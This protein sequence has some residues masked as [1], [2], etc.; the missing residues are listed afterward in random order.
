MAEYLRS[1]DD[2]STTYTVFEPDQ[3]L[4]ETEL[5]AAVYYLDDQERLSRVELSGVGIVCGLRVSVTSDVVKLTKGIGVTTDGDL[6]YAKAVSSTDEDD[7]VHY[8][9]SDAYYSN[10]KPYIAGG[11]GYQRF[12]SGTSAI[13]AWELV[14]DGTDDPL[15]VS[16]GNF[17]TETGHSFD[18]MAALLLVESYEK[19]K[20]LCSGTDCDN[21]GKSSI[22]DVKLILIAK[23]ATGAFKESLATPDSAARALDDI[24]ATRAIINDVS[25]VS[26]FVTAHR[27]ACTAMLT[28]LKAALPK[29]YPACKPFLGDLFATDPSSAWITKLDGVLASFSSG[30]GIQYCYDFFKDVV[31]T[32]EAFRE[33][34]FDD[35]SVCCPKL[36]DFPKHLLLGNLNAPP[37]ST[38][39]RTGYYPSPAS[40]CT[41]GRLA[42]A[43]FLA[44]K[45]GALVDAFSL[46]SA[47]APLRVTPSS[48]EDVPLEERAIPYYYAPTGPSGVVDNWSYTLS[49][50]GMNK[51]NYGYHRGAYGAKGAAADPWLAQVGRF[52]FIRIEGHLGMK[53][54]EAANAIK[55]RIK[56]RNLPIAVDTA[57]LDSDKTKIVPLRPKVYGDLER[58]YQ[59]HRYALVEQI[60]TATNYTARTKT[61][62]EEAHMGPDDKK[63]AIELTK[64]K[65]A[66]MKR[67]GSSAMEKLSASY[68]VFQADAS[69]RD[70]VNDT[71]RAAAEYKQG[72]SKVAKTEHTTPLDAFIGSIHYSIIGIL[73][74]ILQGK[75]DKETEKDLFSKLLAKHPGLEHFAGV[76]RGG[77]FVL[78]Y[79][80]SGVVVGD[81]MVPYLC[82]E[83]DEAETEV[84]P[85][86]KK[87]PKV[88]P[89]AVFGK[90][91]KF[92]PTIASDIEAKI[93]G[94][95]VKR[96]SVI[97]DRI[98]AQRVLFQDLL[99]YT[100]RQREAPTAEG[101][102]ENPY[103]AAFVHEIRSGEEKLGLLMARLLDPSNGPAEK[104]KIQ[105]E[106]KILETGMATTAGRAADMVKNLALDVKRGS[107]G[108][109][110]MQAVARS[111]KKIREPAAL[112]LLDSGL[113]GASKGASP[114]LAGIIAAINE[115]G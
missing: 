100:A 18:D 51:Y 16:L 99:G 12:G 69:W 48:C 90:G 15:K 61:L 91:M 53:V 105:G 33:A 108:F 57:L 23:S 10:F 11:P 93:N 67:S 1:L 98:R 96:E 63:E 3:V 103:A 79:D 47:G 95:W 37:D 45:I 34:L 17:A 5:N 29:V 30:T 39:N 14:L 4:T 107:D 40:A 22:H 112:K 20:D 86:K 42:H 89:D 6:L 2:I 50:R 32:Y 55:S 72:V 85:K 73:E 31:E 81:V 66:D 54:T 60:E 43:R 111:A 68:E 101:K 80:T 87:P 92:G 38:A 106:I 46:P 77:T 24:V 41:A 26:Q 13:E 62:I 44:R 76:T 70:D 114:E 8:A 35:T 64:S 110:V 113:N 104:K 21:Q 27:T 94:D 78:L 109:E 58:I 28:K 25:K 65:S 49:R 36:D 74:G 56:D 82:C 115:R 83:P 59:A 71:M 9:M 84:P 88:W 102:I 7:T 19:D 75:K 97:D 52:D